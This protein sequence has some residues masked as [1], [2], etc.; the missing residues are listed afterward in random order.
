M[1]HKILQGYEV[2]SASVFTP[3]GKIRGISLFRY[4]LTI[5]CNMLYRITFYVKGIKR[6][7]VFFRAYS[8]IAI[9]QLFDVYG[10]NLIESD[11]FGFSAEL[12]VKAQKINLLLSEAPLVLRIDMNTKKSTIKVFKTIKEYMQIVINNLKK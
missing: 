5:G 10:D 12:L 4:V 11:G 7:T 8:Y 2:F 1:I 3:G 6:F 9:K